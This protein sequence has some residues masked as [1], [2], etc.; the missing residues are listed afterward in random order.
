MTIP[1]PHPP[2]FQSCPFGKLQFRTRFLAERELIH[3]RR[4]KQAGMA[5]REECRAYQCPSCGAWH[6]TRQQSAA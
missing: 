1:C 3:T 2:P 4:K 6:L 5:Y